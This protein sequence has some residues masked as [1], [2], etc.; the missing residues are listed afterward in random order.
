MCFQVLLMLHVFLFLSPIQMCYYFSN[1]Y[2]FRSSIPSCFEGDFDSNFLGTVCQILALHRLHYYRE[3]IMT[4]STMEK[5]DIWYNGL[6]IFKLELYTL[7]LQWVVGGSNPNES[8]D[9]DGG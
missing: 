8:N 5:S 4:K 6:A 9:D 7:Q 2:I 1:M 3:L